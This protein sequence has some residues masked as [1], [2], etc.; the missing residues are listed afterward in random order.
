MAT[1]DFLLYRLNLVD[2]QDLFT[3]KPITADSELLQ[4]IEEATKD[5]YDIPRQGKRASYKWSLR[6]VILESVDDG[7]DVIIF[8]LSR[9][10]ASR[11]GLIVTAKGLAPGTSTFNPP[12][13]TPVRVLIDLSRHL[14]AVEEVPS[15][16]QAHTGWTGILETILSQA[17]W[18]LGLTSVLRLN[19]VV[20]TDAIEARLRAFDRITRLRLTLRI[21]NPDLGPSFRPLY[22]QMEHGGVRELTQDMR[23]ERGLKMD[24]E[25]LAREAIEMALRGYRRGNVRVYGFRDGTKDEFIISD[26]VA[27]V[28][29]EELRD[30]VEAY[31]A[32]QTSAQVRRFAEAIIQRIDE[33][34]RR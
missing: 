11:R 25:S 6:N 3:Q 26:G 22:D 28:Q 1:S 23:N 4:V 7:R 27:R 29:I 12:P 33:N 9:E 18:N 20:P 5:S 15:I 2:R 21:P 34:I 32:G 16:I 19:P 30:F 14:V 24:P 17:A 10:I 8:T 31:A 13:A